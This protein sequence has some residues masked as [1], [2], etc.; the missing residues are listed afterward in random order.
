MREFYPEKILIPTPFSPD[1]KQKILDEFIETISDLG[2][3]NSFS[4]PWLCHPISEKNDLLPDNLF[5][6]LTDFLKFVSV[7]TTI[8]ERPLVFFTEDTVLI[9]NMRD[10]LIENKIDFRIIGEGA[11]KRAFFSASRD[12]IQNV[13]RSI[14]IFSR[15]QRGFMVSRQ[16]VKKLDKHTPYTLIRTWFDSRSPSL[17][18]KGEDV[19]FGKLPHYL[20]SNGFNVLYFGDFIEG[21]SYVE[22][23]LLRNRKYPI[24]LQSALL[25]GIDFMKAVIFQRKIGKK[26]RLKSGLK[27]FGI[28]T[29][30]VYR[31]YVKTQNKNQNIRTNYLIYTAA[32]KL[33]NKFKIQR[34]YM[35]FENY[36]WE[37][38]TWKAAKNA[39]ADTEV[40]SFQHS[41]V[42]L[43]STKFF[44]GKKE[45]QALPFPKKIFT[46]GS[47][48]RD[49]LVHRKNYPRELLKVG[50][51]LRHGYSLPSE[52]VER[53][54]S[55]RVLVQLWT[56][57]KSIRMINFLLSDPSSLSKYH[58]SFNTHPCHP[59]KK[60]IKF[61]DF[62]IKKNFKV[63][64]GFLSKNMETND[65]VVYHGTTTCLDALAHGLP[66]VHVEFD[67]FLS[68]DPLLDFHDFKWIVKTTA[69]LADILDDIYKL[70][71]DDF[72][73]RQKS[74]FDFVRKY[75]GPVNE[76][77][78]SRFMDA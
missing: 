36:A 2:E 17:L 13:Y 72:Y 43:N 24:L 3:D 78:L 11:S 40:F 46:L 74:G 18:S 77:G 14:K 28:N 52:S 22:D 7:I 30:I 48:T 25:H 19:Y 70:S 44:M 50:C 23:T 76:A 38:L 15:I 58:F 67:D 41:Q 56:F 69:E 60:L 61:L 9:R 37:K 26:I 45:L 32:K 4:V 71:D 8:K 34:I 20:Q 75:F 29:D 51:A 39:K 21:F 10:Y 64:D 33:L 59:M 54:R 66:V 31:N 73:A 49:F 5:G 57:E 27:L 65:V 1:E 35:P 63:A 12:K 62:P 68:P 16:S 53:G 42:A 47:T 6:R 55:N